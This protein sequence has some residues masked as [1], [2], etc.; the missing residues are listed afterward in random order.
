MYIDTLATEIE[1]LNKQGHYFHKVEKA[2]KKARARMK[3]PIYKCC[4]NDVGKQ[5]ALLAKCL[6]EIADEQD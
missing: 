5:K 2:L 1:I 3:L 4:L 6:K